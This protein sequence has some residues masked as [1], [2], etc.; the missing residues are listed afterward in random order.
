MQENGKDEVESTNGRPMLH[1]GMKSTKRD[2]QTDPGVGVL[3]GKK[4]KDDCRKSKKTTLKNTE[5]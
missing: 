3:R 1:L 5:P 2:R 4:D